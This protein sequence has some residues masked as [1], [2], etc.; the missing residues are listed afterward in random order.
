MRVVLRFPFSADDTAPVRRRFSRGDCIKDVL[1]FT[2]AKGIE[3]GY[4]EFVVQGRQGKLSKQTDSGL[5]I[6]D[7]TEGNTLR[8][9]MEW[10]FWYIDRKIGH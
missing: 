1:Q 5:G 6:G 7:L 4:V 10:S 8:M 3:L 9:D 2:V